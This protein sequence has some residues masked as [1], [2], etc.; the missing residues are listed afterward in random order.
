MTV[1]IFLQVFRSTRAH[2]LLAWKLRYLLFFDWAESA[3]ALL[4]ESDIHS[5]HK[6]Q[7]TWP[8]RHSHWQP[9][10]TRHSSTHHFVPA[11]S[12]YYSHVRATCNVIYYKRAELD[13]TFCLNQEM[14]SGLPF[15]APCLSRVS[16]SWRLGALDRRQNCIWNSLYKRRMIGLDAEKGNDLWTKWMLRT[17]SM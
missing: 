9:A 5:R 10:A 14:K 11:S 8:Y 17:Y 4:Y 3:R 2:H 13:I 1:R 16:V 6:L 15:P 12:S 7:T